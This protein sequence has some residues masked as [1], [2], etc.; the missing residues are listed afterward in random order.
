MLAVNNMY[1]FTKSILNIYI[2]LNAFYY[3]SEFVLNDKDI[4]PYNCDK[5]EQFILKGLGK[6]HWSK[7]D[8]DVFGCHE[9]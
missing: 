8:P 7:S 1:S 9:S 3:F 6:H 5:K 2:L 4:F